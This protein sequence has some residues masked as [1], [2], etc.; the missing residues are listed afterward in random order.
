MR[1]QDPPPALWN[2][3]LYNKDWALDDL[4]IMNVTWQEAQDYCRS[5]DGRLPT[6]AEWEYAV[7]AG[8]DGARYGRLRDIAQYADNSSETPVSTAQ[9]TD[10]A[11]L[12][13]LFTNRNGMAS[14]G[15]SA[16]AWSLTDML[17][18]VAEWV[19]DEYADTLYSL[20]AGP[21]T[22]PPAHRT[23]YAGAPKVVRGGSWASRPGD[24][25]AS[26]RARQAPD[27]RSV[28]VGFRCVWEGPAE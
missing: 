10:E 25:R 2:G 16:N 23:G 1:A 8:T 6:E 5:V 3:L 14:P 4:P 12:G 19:E 24:V 20:R 18:N 7:R 9:M 28:S 22:D 27:E 15:R 11:L 13:T 21:A 17:G 26:A